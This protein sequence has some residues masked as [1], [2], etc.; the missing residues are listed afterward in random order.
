MKISNHAIKRGQQRGINS[1]QIKL[2]KTFGTAKRVPGNA[3]AYQLTKKKLR[4]ISTM[5]RP[6]FIDKIQGIVIICDAL[7]GDVITCYH[8]P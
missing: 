4:E 7:E 1:Y 2:I 3:Y 5:L 6:Q 8:K